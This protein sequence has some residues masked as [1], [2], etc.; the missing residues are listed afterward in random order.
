MSLLT[1]TREESEA[2]VEEMDK[3]TLPDEFGFRTVSVL[4]LRINESYASLVYNYV[5]QLWQVSIKYSGGSA[6]VGGK[7]YE[8]ALELYIAYTDKIIKCHT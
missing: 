4:S 1:Q 5:S 3:H 8:E 7:G 6:G 2:F